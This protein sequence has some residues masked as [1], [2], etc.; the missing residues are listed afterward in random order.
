MKK[1]A[2]FIDGKWVDTDKYT[3]VMNPAIGEVI[4]QV[5]L[6]RRRHVMMRLQ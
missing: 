1:L 3:A 6:S 4:T 5:P 2:N